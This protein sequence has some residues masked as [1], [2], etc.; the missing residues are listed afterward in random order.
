MAPVPVSI[1]SSTP[2]QIPTT[3][4]FLPALPNGSYIDLPSWAED[5][6]SSACT[7]CIWQRHSHPYADDGMQAIKRQYQPSNRKRQRAYGYLRRLKTSNGRNV[8]N[9]RRHKGR[10]S[11]GV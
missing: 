2:A 8:L 7:Q 11:V 1:P 9:R 4:D 5:G 6:K 3:G 10:W